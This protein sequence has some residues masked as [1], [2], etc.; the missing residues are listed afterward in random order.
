MSSESKLGFELID[1]ISLA[2]VGIF[3]DFP[4]IMVLSACCRRLKMR[5]LPSSRAFVM[6]KMKP[7]LRAFKSPRLTVAGA[8]A[9]H[10]RFGFVRD[11]VRADRNLAF[12]SACSAGNLPIAKWL[13]SDYGLTGNDVADYENGALRTACHQSR[14]DLVIWLVETFGLNRDDLFA[15]HG[16]ALYGACVREDMSLLFWLAE[17]FG[18]TASDFRTPCMQ[19]PHNNAQ[20]LAK[21]AARVQRSVAR[22]AETYGSGGR[23]A[24][25]RE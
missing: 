5:F 7:D 14:L 2:L 17:H 20:K 21:E 15:R 11:Q 9:L 24:A 1:D 8:Q 19:A 4:S 16:V 3:S 23:L 18:L 12:R 25:R 22:I 13:V 10:I 6:M